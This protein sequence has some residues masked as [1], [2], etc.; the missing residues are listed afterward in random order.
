M[1]KSS[2]SLEYLTHEV[3]DDLYS[4]KYEKTRYPV[5]DIQKKSISSFSMRNDQKTKISFNFN[6]KKPIKAFS[7]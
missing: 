7:K 2:N 1:K 3:K 6:I 4:L 5:I